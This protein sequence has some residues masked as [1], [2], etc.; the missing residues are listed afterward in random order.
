MTPCSQGE[1]DTQFK[2]AEKE[3]ARLLMRNRPA[4]L[5]TRCCYYFPP[6]V[7]VFNLYGRYEE[8]GAEVG[9]EGRPPGYQAGG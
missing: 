9:E 2:M 6:P 5:S 1:T 7:Q 3:A 4:T 8:S